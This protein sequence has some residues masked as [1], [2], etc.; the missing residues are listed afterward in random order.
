MCKVELLVSLSVKGVE[1]GEK[2]SGVDAAVEWTAMAVEAAGV[3]VILLGA[4]IATYY[5]L[6]QSHPEGL[7]AYHHFRTNLGRSILLGLE[8]LVAGDII[9][10]VAM[11]PTLED[12]AILA[13]IIAIRTFL[14]FALE[15]EIYGRWPWQRMSREDHEEPG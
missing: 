9:G 13:A 10:T 1:V 2:A 7:S 5:F 4:V 12:L 11:H 14:S 8:F 15:V 3:A 6:K